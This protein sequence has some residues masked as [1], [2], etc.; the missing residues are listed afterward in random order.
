[1]ATRISAG[2]LC[3]DVRLEKSGKLVVVG[4]YTQD[5]VFQEFPATIS[6]SIVVQLHEVADGATKIELRFSHEEDEIIRLRGDIGNAP[7]TPFWITLPLPP[8]TFKKEALLKVEGKTSDGDWERIFT[9]PIK[10]MPGV[11]KSE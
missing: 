6:L 2:F 3:D 1:M 4:M 8:L 7:E 11:S 9:I 10:V 5:I